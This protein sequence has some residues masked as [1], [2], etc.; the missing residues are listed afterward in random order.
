MASKY[1]DRLLAG[2][3]VSNIKFESEFGLKM[4]KKM[5]WSEGKGLGRE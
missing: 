2:T 4:L 5:G 3:G 1:R